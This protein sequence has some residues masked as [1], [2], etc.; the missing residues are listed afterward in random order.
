MSVCQVEKYDA[1]LVVTV[2]TRIIKSVEYDPRTNKCEGFVLPRTQ[3]GKLCHN[4]YTMIS[5]DD[6]EQYFSR[7]TIAYVYAI[8]PLKEGLPSFCFMCIGTDNRFTYVDVC[9]R[10]QYI[11]DQLAQRGI[12]IINF[13][14]DGD[15]HLL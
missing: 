1:P 7:N 13:A 6:V 5:F 9:K 8:Q 2:A 4:T 12:G 15:S 11:Y 10:W 3:E 14:A